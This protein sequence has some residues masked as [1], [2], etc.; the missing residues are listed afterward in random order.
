MKK[1]KELFAEYNIILILVLILGY[2]VWFVPY[3][4]SANN[5]YK[6]LA[7]FGVYGIAAIGMSFLLISG[8]NRPV[9]GH[10]RGAVYHCLLADRLPVRRCGR[11]ACGG[12]SMRPCGGLQRISGDKA[13]DQ[14]ADRIH[15]HHDSPQ[16]C[17]LYPRKSG[18]TVPNTSPFLQG[19]YGFR[20]FGLKFL[21]LPV[22]LFAL[23][24]IGFGL[25]LHRTRFGNGI[26]VAGGNAEAGYSA[27]IEIGVTKT[28]CFII[29]GVCAG[30]TGVLLSS[31]V[32]AG[33]VSY[34]EGLNI[35]LISAS[36][37]GG[38]KFTGGKGSVIR[39]LLGI[40]VV[41]AI[42][43][44]A[45]LLS[46]FDAWAQ[47]ILTGALLL[48]VLNSQTAAP[49]SSAWRMPVQLSFTADAVTKGGTTDEM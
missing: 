8:E 36:V 13:A 14:L 41:R 26:Y 20:L 29:G 49:E 7:D 44:I 19:L 16:W 25:L 11:S 2:G 4:A 43:N 46:A 32:Y 39:T 17:V 12:C 45:S 18:A 30:I 1:C 9:A 38:V 15:C 48:A 31:Y 5:V 27:G 40:I 37:L 28:I 3:F 34:G 33:A 21:Q 6:L 35:T 22:L 10:V 23:C 42:I 24:L 47:N